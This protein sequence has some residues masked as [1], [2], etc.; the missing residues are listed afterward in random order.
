MN[1]SSTFEANSGQMIQVNFGLSKNLL[2]E[3]VPRFPGSIACNLKPSIVSRTFLQLSLKQ[4]LKE[5]RVVKRIGSL[6]SKI[7]LKDME[8][9]TSTLLCFQ[10]MHL[11]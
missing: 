9:H 11:P 2:P 1:L 7:V 10:N 5:L 8:E 3:I 4:D 6:Q